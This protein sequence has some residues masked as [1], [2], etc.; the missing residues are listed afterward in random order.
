MVKKPSVIYFFS[1]TLQIEHVSGYGG[2]VP[3]PNIDK[4]INGGMK[5]NRAVPNSP[6]CSPARYN[7]LTG[8]YVSRC[9]GY[10]DLYTQH[11][12]IFIRWNVNLTNEEKTIATEFKYNGYK[13][14]LVGK[15]HLGDACVEQFD[16]SESIY[17]D[18]TAKK[19]KNNY[20]KSKDYVKK[21]SGFD[22][23]ESLFTNNE[24]AI[25]MPSDAAC[26]H[27]MH[28]ITKGAIDFL[29]GCGNDPFFLLMCPNLPHSPSVLETLQN[30]AQ[31][32]PAG[33]LCEDISHIQA[34][35]RS[36]LERLDELGYAKNPTRN[37]LE[38]AEK[39]MAARVIWLDDGLGSII[40]YI[41][42]RGMM[43]DVIF[44]V[45]TDHQAKG[46]MTVHRQ[47][48]PLA[49]RW[50]GMITSNTQSDALVSHVDIIKTLTK[51]CN[52]EIEA[53]YH[54]D[55]K[56]FSRILID[57]ILEFENIVFTEVAYAKGIMTKDYNYICLDYPDNISNRIRNN[58]DKVK[59]QEGI[60]SCNTRFNALND[61]PAYFD[62][63]Q[64]YSYESDPNEKINLINNPEFSDIKAYLHDVLINQV[65]EFGYKFSDYIPNC[66]DEY[67]IRRGLFTNISICENCKHIMFDIHYN[68]CPMCDS[69]NFTKNDSIF[70][71]SEEIQAEAILTHT[72]KIEYNLVDSLTLIDVSTLFHD[73]K[74]AHY[75]EFADI[76]INYKFSKRLIEN[77]NNYKL[78]MK[79]EYN[80]IIVIIKC[81]KHGYWQ[82][83]L[84]VNRKGERID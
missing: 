42:S 16:D 68:R 41:E 26:E 13:T 28:W 65:A 46:K 75:I 12:P 1:D 5:F 66:N 67:M 27:N 23:V 76:Y 43:D 56:D 48:C 51:L 6:V 39:D 69:C 37:S 49:F 53:D 3:T 36:I 32:T 10:R 47:H 50:D 22:F 52:L 81:S 29:E 20:M 77:L 60:E 82:R 14:G 19:V 33:F 84:V 30:N 45:N 70:Y 72:P 24:L 2:S 80:S 73:I 63:K 38:Y 55:G 21:H 9:K 64:L 58:L 44:V 79:Q 35:C 31:L 11:D 25:P 83:E 74:E 18:F 57:N 78:S 71:E 62:M 61:F 17:D 59:N 8:R 4:I 40:D 15:W 54:I 34:S 7:V